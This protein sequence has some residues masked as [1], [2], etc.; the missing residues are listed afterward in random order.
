MPSCKDVGVVLGSRVR[1]GC[2]MKSS[3]HVVAVTVICNVVYVRGRVRGAVW[4]GVA[5]GWLMQGFQHGFCRRA[6][7]TKCIHIVKTVFTKACGGVL[8]VCTRVP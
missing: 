1:V 8:N 5:L 4:H 3:Q 6:I 7:A 2:V